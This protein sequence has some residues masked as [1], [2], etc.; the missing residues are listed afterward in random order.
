MRRPELS[1]ASLSET[2]MIVIVD[3]KVVRTHLDEEAKKL[4]LRVVRQLETSNNQAVGRLNSAGA[5]EMQ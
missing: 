2:L 3:P 1:N 4:G 5:R